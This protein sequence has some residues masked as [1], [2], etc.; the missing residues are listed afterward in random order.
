MSGCRDVLEYDSVHVTEG[1]MKL[2]DQSFHD[3]QLHHYMQL[4][5]LHVQY[6]T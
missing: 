2:A 6:Q 1:M 3:L 5:A 4:H